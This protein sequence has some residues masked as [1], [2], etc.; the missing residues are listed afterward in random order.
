MT[1]TDRVMILNKMDRAEEAVKSASVVIRLN[2][3][4]PRAHLSHGM[5]LS[6][7]GRN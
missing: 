1:G 5:A 6:M 7:L 4:N 2:A 3:E